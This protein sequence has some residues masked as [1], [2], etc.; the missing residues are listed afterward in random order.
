[1]A[2][3]TTGQRYFG[4]RLAFLT[5]PLQMNRTLRACP[6]SA[7]PH[8]AGVHAATA[9]GGERLHELDAMRSV[10]ML[11]GIVLHAA[12]PYCVSAHWM[13]ADGA[14]HEAFDLL[15]EVIHLFRMPAFFVVAGYFAM[16]LLRRRT[17]AAFLHERLR[18]TLLPAAAV[19]ATFNL[20]QTWLLARP[21]SAATF[22]HET[23]PAAWRSGAL[24]GHLWFL[25]Y[26]ALY[27][28][29]LA[30]LRPRL[31]RWAEGP[32]P[33]RLARTRPFLA[34]L[35]VTALVPVAGAGMA[36]FVPRLAQ[37]V[38]GLFDPVELLGYAACFA[39]G[40][41][42]QASDALLRRFSA[43]GLP[44]WLAA[45]AGLT[46]WLAPHHRHGLAAAGTVLAGSLLTWCL[47]RLLFAGFRRWTRHPSR[48]LR[49]LSDASYSMY[50]F[51][52]L[53][54]VA[55]ATALLPLAWPAAAKFTVV[56]AGASLLSL[57]IHH[58]LVRPFAPMRWLFNGAAP[59]TP[60]PS[61]S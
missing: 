61:A 41:A 20:A 56:L 34:M 57:A 27:C 22:V 50:L 39:V 53:F 40:C 35:G 9:T 1:M 2:V 6:T 44:T 51:H 30:P 26:L 36:H 31:L 12:N 60:A 18:R 23:L 10:L 16:L 15:D 33:G 17:R 13:V 38:L 24:P 55:I 14:R 52:H 37:P 7:V 58:F 11:L 28:L 19:L 8:A 25:I 42:L 32:G 49:Y 29:A 46:L 54:V 21:A 45:A 43:P 47:V 59:L 5:Q 3:A 4:I 48:G